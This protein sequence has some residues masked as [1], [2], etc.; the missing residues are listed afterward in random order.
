M[1]MKTPINRRTF[2][3]LISIFGMS[4]SANV[5][6]ASNISKKQTSQQRNIFDVQHHILP[7]VYTNTLEKLGIRISGGVPIPRFWDAQQSL[8]A[9]D[10]NGI[11]TAITSISSPGIYFGDSKFSID[12]AKRCNEY[13]ANLVRDNQKRFGGFAVLPLPDVEAALRE[14]EYAFDT[15]KLD[16]VVLLTNVDGRY[17]GSSRFDELFAEL[18]RRKAIVYIHPTTP[19]EGQFPKMRLP[20][21]ILEFVFDTTGA[22]SNLILNNTLDRFPDIR[23]IVAHAGGTASYLAFR[24]SLLDYFRGNTNKNTISH[25]KNLYYDT[26]LSAS[27]YTLRSLQELADS[28][29]IVFG[30][31]YPFATEAVTSTTISELKKY[32]GFDQKGL[33]AIDR[34]NALN[35]FPR[36]ITK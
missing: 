25:L 13:S 14:L 36:F 9:M 28:S 10:R 23:F 21:A 22:I 5:V 34:E 3:K 27:P 12:L 19:P 4:F 26:A 33:K 17:L 16:G 2:L 35:L 18:N 20:P 30:S 1:N 15:L 31:D 11:A 7:P 32:D 6:F 24:I 29:H 8:N